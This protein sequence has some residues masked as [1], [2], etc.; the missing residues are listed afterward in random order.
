MRL[1]LFILYTLTAITGF[2]DEKKYGSFIL[3]TDIPD[4]LFFI[5]EIKANDSFEL[6]KAL[7]NHEIHNIVLASPGGSIWEGLQMAGIIFDKKLRTYVPRG[8]TCAS[9]CSYLFFAGHERLAEGELGVHQA[10][11]INSQKQQAIG[12]TQY[13]TQFTVSEIIG[14]LNEFGT[15]AF[16]YERM[17]QDIDMY[18]FDPLELM[19]LNS[20]TFALEN[21]EKMEATKFI[22]RKIKEPKE[23]E[24]EL[25][26]KE[27]ITLIQKRLKEVG[28][29][30]GQADGIWG[31]RTQA[32][33]VAF[34]KKAGLPTSK[35]ELISMKFIEKLIEAPSNYCPKI[36]PP[37]KYFAAKYHIEC[38][39]VPPG[40]YANPGR[41]NSTS[42]DRSTGRGSFEWEWMKINERGT[43]PFKLVSRDR[44]LIEFDDSTQSAALKT[45]SN[46][47]VTSF[48]YKVNYS[49]CKRYTAYAR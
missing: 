47:L 28:C 22:L 25:T 48:S 30:P 11:S 31:K 41:I 43:N 42:F 10:K 3:N 9:A 49:Y 12:Q 34:A 36:K 37:M 18:F 16:V 44:I 7:R 15:P 35:D 20:G 19:E 32:A 33:A 8:G 14:F 17:F 27:M 40:A 6:R 46:G 26:R 45:N 29:N 23:K 21:S 2:A 4:T 13:V 38:T 5:D 24:P 39:D 1:L